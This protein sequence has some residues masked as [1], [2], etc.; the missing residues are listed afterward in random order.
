MPDLA[1]MPPAS[2]CLRQGPCAQVLG[3][4]LRHLFVGDAA[5]G[6]VAAHVSAHLYPLL[7][8]G[9]VYQRRA[10]LWQHVRPPRDQQQGRGS[11]AHRGSMLAR[12]PAAQGVRRQA[13]P[14]A[15]APADAP[16]SAAPTW[17]H[18]L[19]P[20]ALECDRQLELARQTVR[21]VPCAA[22]YPGVVAP[23]TA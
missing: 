9:H 2:P 17:P 3:V 11:G 10:S 1:L 21:H 23:E 8:L 7:S 15:S 4:R 19:K 5:P 18:A 20:S 13:T 12:A 22:L 14:Q 16:T 6:A